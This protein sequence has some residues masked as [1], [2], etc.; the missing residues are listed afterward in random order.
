METS[1]DSWIKKVLKWLFLSPVNAV[2]ILL[3]TYY[4]VRIFLLGQDS[5]AVKAQGAG[6]LFLWILWFAAKS[7]IK[8][9][10]VVMLVLAVAYGWYQY[11]RHDE[12]VC[13]DNGGNWNRELKICEEKLTLWQQIKRMM[14]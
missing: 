13:K 9:L 3:L 10:F 7:I 4:G 12:I 14:E 5:M 8:L 2:F 1:K 6:V 11:S